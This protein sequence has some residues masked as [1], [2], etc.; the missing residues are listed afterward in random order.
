FLP[1]E[2]AR[3]I[4][5]MAPLRALTER[6]PTDPVVLERLLDETQARG[7]AVSD[8]E[9]VPG[10]RVV[11]APILDAGRTAIAAV[12]VA[13]PAMGS[14]EDFVA[15]VTPPLVDVAQRL[16]RALMAS[17]GAASPTPVGKEPVRATARRL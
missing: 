8:Q 6:T 10:L 13:E 7:F 16:S 1:R 12:S 11:A 4:I 9:V 15:E 3:A 14:L 2:Q 17:G 5:A